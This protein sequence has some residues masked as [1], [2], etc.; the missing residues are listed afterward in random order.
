[1][2]PDG[3]SLAGKTALVTG[4]GAGIGRAC[5][6]ELARRGAD[7]IV[8]DRP[9]SSD[10]EQTAA[11]VR[12]LGCSC[13][14]APA[15]VFCRSGCEQV[16]ESGLRQ[17]G[18]IDI[19]ISNPAYSRRSAFLDYDPD[20]F[21]RTIQATLTSGFH[22]AQLVARHLT[23]RDGGG[24]IV[25][26]SSVQA[27]RPYARSCAYGP[28]KAALNHLMRTIAVELAPHRVN[29]NA[30]DPGWIETPGEHRTFGADVLRQEGARLPWG[31]LGQPEDI[32]RAAAFLVSDE[33]D[34][35]SG[36]VLTVDGLF[37]YRDCL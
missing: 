15:D 31:R 13:H 9:D 24:R 34:Y 37:R 19:L 14:M 21:E 26:I 35:I 3:R 33:A 25:F 28:A 8:N 30:I 6:L 10:L 12:D 1:M 32:A 20:D 4:A 7:L 2:T 16:V 18:R 5:A 27:E 23:Q 17:A 22:M 11:E 36:T 29:V